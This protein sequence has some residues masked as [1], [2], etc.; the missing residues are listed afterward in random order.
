MKARKTLYADD[1]AHVYQRS[2]QGDVIFYDF[3]DML[4]FFTILSVASIKH[5][6]TIVAICI[7]L[8]HDHILL[9]APSQKDISMFMAEVNSKF[10][11]EYNKDCPGY[12]KVFEPVFKQSNKFGDKN[13]RNVIAY[14]YNNYVEKKAVVRAEDVRWNFLAFASSDH[15]FSGKLVVR[16]ASNAMKK[17][18]NEVRYFHGKGM[19]VTYRLLDKWMA[20]ISAGPDPRKEKAQLIDCIIATYNVINYADTIK[21]Y[22]SLDSMILAINSN[23]G[24][25]YEVGEEI[26]KDSYKGFRVM[27]TSLL[28]DY[29]LARPK[30][31][32]RL[33]EEERRKI[34]WDF[35]KRRLGSK[36]QIE[37]LLHIEP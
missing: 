10:A 13:T 6:V 8:N 30:L 4:V 12:G 33:P 3:R 18:L 37:R 31:V 25:D 22:K 27:M 17:V 16:R 1:I 15:P 9:D 7:M 5:H 36:Y 28:R 26:E 11:I 24:S 23:T 35:M 14:C 32:L 20:M 19:P 2:I 29:G 21:Y 34:G